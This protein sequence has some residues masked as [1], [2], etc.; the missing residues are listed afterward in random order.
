VAIE[1]ERCQLLS[2]GKQAEQQIE[3]LED[4]L[5]S[6]D[7][8]IHLLREENLKLRQQSLCRDE[9]GPHNLRQWK[10]KYDTLSGNFVTM[11]EK[12]A[13]TTNRVANMEFEKKA[14]V[15]LNQA[16]QAKVL[17]AEN[18]T[19]QET[20][21]MKEVLM[22]NASQLADLEDLLKEKSKLIDILGDRLASKECSEAATMQSLTSYHDRK[23]QFA[24]RQHE[25]DIQTIQHHHKQQINALGQ[26]LSEKSAEYE[27]MRRE[28]DSQMQQLMSATAEIDRFKDERARMEGMAARLDSLNRE[29]KDYKEIL[30]A[31]D[32][33]IAV[34]RA[35]NIK[36]DLEMKY[37]TTPCSSNA[38]HPTPGRSASS[39]HVVAHVVT[40]LNSLAGRSE[41]LG[42]RFADN[43]Y[44]EHEEKLSHA[45]DTPAACAT[46]TCLHEESFD[47]AIETMT[48]EA[49]FA[50]SP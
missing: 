40:P 46:V 42:F 36:K 4:E 14:L 48:D 37:V 19:A 41:M 10:Q 33:K 18:R 9:S 22:H 13:K 7:T 2:R 35:D 17:R 31:K 38:Y 16:L 3:T 28:F 47:W 30:F 27:A 24:R 49:R 25:A 23:L 26:Q 20:E 32:T 5:S 39:E 50:N 45:D 1:G 44:L 43:D 21:N 6:K 15:S 34:L 8:Q 12:L 29:C 11:S